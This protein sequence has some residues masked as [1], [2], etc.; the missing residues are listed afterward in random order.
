[1]IFFVNYHSCSMQNIYIALKFLFLMLYCFITASV[2]FASEYSKDNSKEDTMLIFVGEDLQVLTLASRREESAWQAPAIANVFTKEQFLERG[3]TTLSDLL[4]MSAGFHSSKKEWGSHI[5]LRGIP[6]SVLL[7]YD[8]V[9]IS[10]DTTKSLNF[11]D[12]E[13][14]LSSIKRVEIIRGPGSVLWGPDAFAG[15]VNVVP[16]SGKDIDGIEAGVL[17]GDYGDTKG[18]FANYGYDG[19][20]WDTFLSVN[21]YSGEQNNKPCNLIK[22]WGNGDVPVS[23]EDRMGKIMPEDAYFLESFG[24][25]SYSDL[26]NISLR[27]S[28]SNKP[29]SIEDEKSGLIWRENRELQSGFI[30]FESKKNIDLFSALRIMGVYSWLNPEY[31]IIDTKLKQKENTSYVEIIY[32]RTSFSGIGLFTCGIS[33]REKRIKDAPIWDS[34]LPDYLVKENKSFLPTIAKE[35]YNTQLISFFSQYNHKIGNFDLLLG[36]RYDEHDVY[37]DHISFNTGIVWSPKKEWMCKILYGSAYR[38]PSSKQLIEENIPDLEKIKSLN[39]QM[40]LKPSEDIGISACVFLS[41]IENH[42]IEDPYAGLSLPNEQEINGIEIEAFVNPLKSLKLSSNITV[43]KNKGEDETYKY[44]DYVYIR[45]DGTI[46]K[47]YVDLKYPYNTGPDLFLNITGTW[48]ANER[49][50]LFTRCNYFASRKLIYPRAKDF[51]EVSGGWTV[52]TS[53]NFSNVFFSKF[54]L[55]LT[56]KNLFDYNYLEPGTYSTIN[57]EPFSAMF[58]LTR[59]W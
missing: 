3:S 21:A 52:D 43:I 39:I 37:K 14:P 35:D 1:M 20:L 33:F 10:L 6:N 50:S 40:A 12:N 56:I 38:T 5:Y 44:N 25:F 59:S 8:T 26:F 22:F 54:D 2:S 7:L 18:T 58:I 32:D 46:E 23:P 17:F 55:T 4:D 48:Y 45:P 28:N 53:L 30:K 36:G 13:L 27:I 31:E 29:Y 34:Y 51:P 41:K 24:R 47:H 15:I 19:G 57:G 42:M 49:L 11:F 9:P 16:L